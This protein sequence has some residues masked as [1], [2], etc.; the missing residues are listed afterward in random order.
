MVQEKDISTADAV[1]A[2]LT[3]EE[4]VSLLAGGSFWST[5][6]IPG[7]SIPSV[8]F[9]DGPNGARG[10]EMKGGP[11]S[12]C[13]PCAVSLAAT[14]NLDA[15]KEVGKALAEETKTKGAN[16]L[17]GPTVCPHRHPLGGRNFESFSEDPFLSGMMASEYIVGLQGQGIGAA[18]KHFA[19]NEQETFRNILDV[20]VSM[21]ALREIYLKPF[22]IAIKQAK[23]WA[24]MTAYNSV[25]G[26]HAD[27]NST[28]LQQILREEWKWDGLVLSDWG[29]TNSL[30][31]SLTAGLDLEMPGPPTVRKS[32]LIMQALE[33]NAIP[34]SIIN[35]R[36]RAVL[37]F[38]ATTTGFGP[39]KECKEYADDRP[40][41]RELIRQ[42][43][44]EG[45]VL[46]KN[47][48]DILPLKHT[49]SAGSLTKIALLG[50]ADEALIHGGGSA[51][52]NAHHRIT[53]AE[54]LRDAFKDRG[55]E[56]ECA[57]GAHTLR[58]LPLMVDHVKNDEGKPGWSMQ[59][60]HPKDP[61]G[62]WRHIGEPSYTPTA[63]GNEGMTV[64]ATTQFC[65]PASGRHYLSLSGLGP[66]SLKINGDEVY[67]QDGN[68]PDLMAFIL[69]SYADIPVQ[70]DFVAGQTYHIEVLSN[71]LEAY[72]GPSFMNGRAGFSVGFMLEAERDAD[73]LA[74][75]VTLA[76]RS[77]IAIILTGNTAEWEAE[78]QDQVGF[79][80]PRDGSQDRLV[81][82]VAAANKSTIVVNC[83]GGPIAM[84][85]IHEV[86]ALL[87]AWFPGQ[88]AGHSIADILVG[89]R[90]PSGRLPVTFPRAIEDT[91]AYRNFPGGFEEDGRAR[92]RYEEGVFVGYRFYDHTPEQREKVLFPFGYG[93]SYTSFTLHDISLAT[94][95]D[96]HENHIEVRVSVS[97][98]GKRRGTETIQVYVG[99][100]DHSEQHPWKTLVAFAQVSLD[101]GETREMS[102]ELS[103]RDLAF[104]DES[105][106]HWVVEASDYLVHVGTSVFE[107]ASTERLHI[108]ERIDYAL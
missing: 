102:L 35:D 107:I 75:A 11:T 44:R 28:L 52:V 104:Y 101:A 26:S 20:T 108:P 15:I 39:Q 84:P 47:E 82:A 66:S 88:E 16:L 93:L 19:A 29:G 13:F 90:F 12:A 18:I 3:L 78:G 57:K 41:H 10:S 85:W 77:D 55:L 86:K 71:P 33:S 32:E 100:A 73:L 105:T 5:A 31:E 61:A 89:D 64:R 65:V 98:V 81:S 70:Y 60:L 103:R 38:V 21:R 49:A 50:F 24:L 62:V 1:L 67:R 106:E 2:S 76:S 72:N 4:K 17:L 69:T 40:S 36:A 95:K 48:D 91:P 83:T 74:E 9:S 58:K 96:H 53:L 94:L 30:V 68:C 6:A 56:I 63:P 27:C 46:L 34:E 7:K 92:V 43:G 25:N 79:H 99:R 51:A 42:V 14:W 37:R 22:E 97:N 87:Q 23:P 80:L 45:I 8:K 54:G 59:F